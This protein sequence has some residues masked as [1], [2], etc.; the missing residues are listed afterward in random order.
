MHG[1]WLG[2]VVGSQLGTPLEFQP[3]KYTQKKYC[4]NRNEEIAYY[5]KTPN[6]Q[7]VN[8]DEI[9]EI[10]GLLALEEKG[11]DITSNDLAQYWD[12]KLYKA[13]YTAE[14]A[15]LKNIRKAFSLLILLVLNMEISGLMR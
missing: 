14:K 15:A 5:V 6:P 13:Q 12:A 10:L 11:I 8:D 7:A 9:Y 2:R 3:Y 1:G 4:D